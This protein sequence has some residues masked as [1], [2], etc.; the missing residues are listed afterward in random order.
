MLLNYANNYLIHNFHTS[1]LLFMD[2]KI[3]IK[4]T[5]VKT[6]EGASLECVSY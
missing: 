3:E 5:I 2:N 4:I 6:V 1:K